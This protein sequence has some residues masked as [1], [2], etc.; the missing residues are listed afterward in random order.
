[1]R[2][3]I[4]S[5]FVRTAYRQAGISMLQQKSTILQLHHTETHTEQL[6]TLHDLGF[7]RLK[8]SIMEILYGAQNAFGYNS[9]KTK[10]IW[11]KSGALRTHCWGLDLAD[12]GRDPSS[13][14]L[15]TV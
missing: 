12:F 14:K 4:V 10:P 11:M 2:H 7:Y 6:T 3:R 15:A 13:S 1:M 8:E 5:R 9:A